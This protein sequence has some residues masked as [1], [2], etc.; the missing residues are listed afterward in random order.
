MLFF[1][2]SFVKFSTM[3]TMQQ[4]YKMW[5]EDFVQ[6]TLLSGLAG[7]CLHQQFDFSAGAAD[8]IPSTC[9]L[10]KEAKSVLS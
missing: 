4:Q 5:Q 3:I 10:S 9:S 1:C 6:V 2:F 7:I 8:P